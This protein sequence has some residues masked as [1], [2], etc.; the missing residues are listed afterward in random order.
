MIKVCAYNT[1]DLEDMSFNK[2]AKK[3][4]KDDNLEK[5]KAFLDINETYT[6]F[7]E[8]AVGILGICEYE[9]GAWYGC[10]IA[11]NDFGRNP[12]YAIKMKWLTKQLI[13]LHNPKRVQTISENNPA[14][15]K[16]HEFIGLR[17]EAILEDNNVLWSMTWE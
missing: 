12:K 11:S 8:K 7:D 13:A 14:L 10:I 15:N 4:E 5:M 16:W 1:D 6:I 3:L 2:Y 17:Q 9:P